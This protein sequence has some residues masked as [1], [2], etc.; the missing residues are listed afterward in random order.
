MANNRGKGTVTFADRKGMGA[1]KGDYPRNNLS[2][3]FRQNFEKLD[4]SNDRQE[5]KELPPGNCRG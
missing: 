5:V 1:G 3:Q 2:E 4:W